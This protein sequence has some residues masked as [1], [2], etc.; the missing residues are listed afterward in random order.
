[1]LLPAFPFHE[2]SFLPRSS[3]WC[4]RLP[5]KSGIRDPE[6]VTE[7]EVSLPQFQYSKPEQWAAFEVAALEQAMQPFQVSPCDSP[8]PPDQYANRDKTRAG[9][10]TR[11]RTICQRVDQAFRAVRFVGIVALLCPQ[12]VLAMSQILVNV[13]PQQREKSVFNCT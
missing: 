13:F 11:D 5:V 6:N 7:A 3:A 12:A 2:T 10:A 9:P 8:K 1:M 4:R